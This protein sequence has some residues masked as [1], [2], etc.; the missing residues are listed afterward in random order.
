MNFFCSLHV[1][2]YY[3]AHTVST[4]MDDWDSHRLG[5]SFIVHFPQPNCNKYKLVL[6]VWSRIVQ[7]NFTRFP[8]RPPQPFLMCFVAL[9]DCYPRRHR[10]AQE[11]STSIP[12][13]PRRPRD[14]LVQNL[15][16]LVP[17]VLENGEEK[18]R[19][20]KDEILLLPGS[21]PAHPLSKETRASLSMI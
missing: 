13:L 17:F 8:I 18:G 15:R 14:L 5:V 12:F 11:Q 4:S 21:R 6:L 19:K 9:R 7:L 1:A 16:R 20:K 3:M 2:A 10:V